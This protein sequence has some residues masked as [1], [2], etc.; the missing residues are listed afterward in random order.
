[1]VILLLEKY[2]QKVVRN[3]GK[4]VCS[5]L[6]GKFE[7]LNYLIAEEQLNKCCTLK[8]EMKLYAAIKYYIFNRYF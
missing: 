8:Y 7:E 2:P 6:F 3:I 5:I 4:N 1:M